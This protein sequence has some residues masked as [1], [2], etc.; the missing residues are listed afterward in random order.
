MTTIKAFQCG[1]YNRSDYAETLAVKALKQLDFSR[2]R[3]ALLNA[4]VSVSLKLRAHHR[5][6]VKTRLREYGALASNCCCA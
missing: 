1:S 2:R 5:K 3:D 4:K 6:L